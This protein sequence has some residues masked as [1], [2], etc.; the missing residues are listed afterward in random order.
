MRKW[1]NSFHGA[2]SQSAKSIINHQSIAIKGD[3]LRDGDDLK[4]RASLNHRELWFVSPVPDYASHTWYSAIEEFKTKNGK[5]IFGQIM[6]AVKVRTYSKLENNEEES[7][8]ATIKK[9]GETERGN[10]KGIDDYNCIPENEVEWFSER[11]G[12]TYPY[13]VLVRIFGEDEKS[14]IE[15]VNNKKI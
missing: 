1:A 3:F 13:G 5:K 7:I 14:E 12:C 4:R 6:L 15:K 10:R 8:I 11:R 9:Q 2:P